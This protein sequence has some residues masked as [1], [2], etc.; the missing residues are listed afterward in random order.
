[1]KNVLK[2]IA[3]A[4]QSDA[5]R[6]DLYL[7]SPMSGPCPIIVWLHP[8]GYTMGDKEMVEP[9][10]DYILERGYAV[11]SMNYRLAY[12]AHFPAQL[13]DAKAAVRWIRANAATYNLNKEAIAAWGVSAGSTFAALLGTTANVLELEDFSMG[14]S[15]ESS[16]VNAV[17]A[18]I[19]PMDFLQIDS[20]LLQLGYQPLHEDVASGICMLI[21]GQLTEYQ[22]RCQAINPATY[23]TT[24]C[25]PFYLQHGT[26]DHLVPYL[27]SVNFA[28]LLIDTIGK[29]NVTLNLLEGV[30]HF[31][32]E[33][34]SLGNINKALDFLDRHIKPN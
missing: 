1:M 3:Y 30:D 32:S 7:P 23:I 20:Q 24:D 8:G 10:I 14:N 29:E 27:Q 34:N 9:V 28:Q 11:A 25:P 19:G 6:L 4:T 13:F 33:H 5:Q 12:E 2:K 22:E 18:L 15:K 31:D 17:V 26:A 21:G 16:Y